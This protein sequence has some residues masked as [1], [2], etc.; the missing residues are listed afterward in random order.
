M[1]SG[2][3]LGLDI[4]KAYIA[5]VSLYTMR[6]WKDALKDTQRAC[7]MIIEI[8]VSTK[9]NALKYFEEQRK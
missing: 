3:V 6:Q 7:A 4:T 1:L 2:I 8:C 5:N 9:I